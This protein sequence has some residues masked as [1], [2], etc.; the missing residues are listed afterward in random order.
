[1]AS[2]RLV[3]SH[4]HLDYLQDPEVS[5]AL[6][7]E[8][9]VSTVVVPAVSPENFDRVQTLGGRHEAV[10]YLLGLHPCYVDR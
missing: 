4:C 7:F 8:A 9:G 3:D 2:L 1:M 10:F 5:L 6:A